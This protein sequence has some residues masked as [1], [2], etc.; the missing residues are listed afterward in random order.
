MEITLTVP[1][2][3][4]DSPFKHYFSLKVTFEDVKG[5]DEAKRELQEVVEFLVNPD[6]FSSLGESRDHIFKGVNHNTVPPPLSYFKIRLIKSLKSKNSKLKKYL[7]NL[8]L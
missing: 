4:V 6:K 7:C 2:S 8:I 1:L 3:C 5:C